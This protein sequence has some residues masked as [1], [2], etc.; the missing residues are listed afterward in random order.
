MSREFGTFRIFARFRGRLPASSR[1]A[2]RERSLTEFLRFAQSTVM[3][4]MCAR[5]DA[6]GLLT[7]QETS[8]PFNLAGTL[9]ARLDPATPDAV[10]RLAAGI[11][12]LEVGCRQGAML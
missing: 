2:Y 7:F 1:T 4:G 10:E 5:V 11:D 8:R 6:G 9:L 3:T 12:V